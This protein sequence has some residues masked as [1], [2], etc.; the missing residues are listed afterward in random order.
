MKRILI[1]GI[2][3]QVGWSCLRVTTPEELLVV[4][5]DRKEC[6]ITD[7][8]SIESCLD[9]LKPNL[10]INPAAYTAVDKAEGDQDNAF[11]V[12]RE[13]AAN[14]AKACAK[15]DIPLIHLSTDYVF[16][17]SKNGAYVEDDLVA[18]NGIYA[19]SKE[20][21]EQEVRKHC[22][23][24]IILRTAWVYCEHG[25]NFVK[26]M[27]RLGAE[28][29]E[30]KIVGDQHGC[31]TYARDIAA[32]CLEIARQLL[33]GSQA[34]GT[35]HFAAAGATTWYDF[36][37]EIF[38]LSDLPQKPILHKI[39]TAEYLTPAQRPAN[40]VLDTTKI[41]KTFSIK[42]RSWQEAL[43]QMMARL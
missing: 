6:D 43:A 23:K 24:H 41:Q 18:P 42:P 16:D 21:G 1:T 25:H 26:T 4:G 5:V 22:P 36:A 33:D 15:R 3:G 20:E 9:R 38:R 37:A 11:A 17:G 12:N 32:A 19:F 40:S 2:N 39:T 7:M 8:A 34:F 31:P 13:G 28:R 29:P 35:Y 10:V 30:L 14:M 27:L